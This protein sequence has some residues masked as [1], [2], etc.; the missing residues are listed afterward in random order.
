MF[1]RTLQSRRESEFGTRPLSLTLVRRMFTYLR[2]YKSNRN[3]LL[4]MVVLRAIQLPLLAWIIGAAIRGP[5]EHHDLH[6]TLGWAAAFVGLA[7]LT[8]V[9]FHFRARLA[10]RMGEW[11]VRDMRQ[12]F[13]AHVL[14]MTMA[15]FHRHKVGQ[16]LSR[17]T[18]DIEAIRV[19]VQDVLFVSIVQLGQMSIACLVMAHYNWRLFLV[20]LALAPVLWVIN[21]HFHRLLSQAHRN[22]HESFSRITAALA[23]TINGIRVTQGFVRQDVN[24]EM[25]AEL[26]A[27]H[28]QYNLGQ[29]RISGVFLP[30]LE[31]NSQ[32]FIAALLVVGG[33]LAI[34]PAPL[35]VP[36]D[37]VNFF[38]MAG[39][40]FNPIGSLGR[41]YDSALS[42]M[43][44]AERVFR[45]LDTGPEWK[46][47]PDAVALT[48]LRGQ[49][50]FRHVTFAYDPG[51]PVLHDICFAVQP[52]QTVAL[53]GHTGCGKST[54]VN[55]IAKFYL[56]QEGQV[57]IDAVPTPHLR[58]ETLRSRLGIVQ[59]QNFL[60]SGSVADNIR[61]GRPSASDAQ[62]VQAAGELGCADLIEALPEGFETH[63]GEKGAGLSLGQRQLVCFARAM[64]ANPRILLLDEAT[65]SVDAMTEARIQRAL[66]R[67]IRGRTCF[68]VAHR[69]STIRRADL[70]LVIERGRIIERGNHEELLAMDGIYADLHRQFVR[71]TSE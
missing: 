28:S 12:Q 50:E 25:F 41:Q 46:D 33:Y 1:R 51:R 4:V 64:L 49:V 5:I 63:V 34:R 43:A 10:L 68:I 16:I 18:N 3:W 58:T 56:P 55:L 47:S 61:L 53:V 32:F 30:L 37:L 31:F 15:F 26:V 14:S 40:F 62:I 21:R 71:S 22:L 69:L 59:Q 17:I 24:A 2:P 60:F 38:F 27:D 39:V 54:I 57:L 19:G 48:E 70:V 11:V 8:Q 9:T 23:E 35:A 42:A 13:F 66:E 29:A 6:G 67:L 45:V 52:G 44:A 7:A 20:V 36:D 65:S